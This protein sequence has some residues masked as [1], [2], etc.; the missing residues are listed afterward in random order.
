LIQNESGPDNL[1][2]EHRLIDERHG[3]IHLP[4]VDWNKDG[5]L[6]F[7][8]LVSQEHEV[9]DVFL[10]RGDATF[11]VETL[12]AASDPAFGSSGIS[13]VDFDKDGDP[14]VLYT[15]GDTMDSYHLRPVHGIRWLE[16]TGSLKLTSH[17]IGPLPGC[18]RALA[19][20]MDQDGDLDVVAVAQLFEKLQNL[21][22]DRERLVW[23]EQ[24]RGTFRQHTVAQGARNEGHLA[25]AVED[26]TGDGSIDFLSSRET[27]TPPANSRP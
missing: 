3:T 24:T 15:N 8:A 25:L 5:H 7:V 6:D 23:F 16:N 22:G 21:D 10:N 2:F 4:P 26:F 27:A 12:Y 20:D 13:L 18:Y 17:L 14:D 9:I 1:S 11:T 19:A